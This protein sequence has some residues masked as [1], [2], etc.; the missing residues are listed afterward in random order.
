MMP[1]GGSSLSVMVDRQSTAHGRELGAELRAIREAAGLSGSEFARRLGWSPSKISRI[2]HGRDPATE[3]DVAIFLG[4][5]DAPSD[6]MDRMLE[7]AR[8]ADEGSLLRLHG[9]K[10]PD[11]LRTLIV[12]ETMA[13]YIRSYESSFIPGLAQTEDYA[14]AVFQE[15]GL[16]PEPGIEL[17]V[18]ARMERQNLL[19]SYNPPEFTAFIHE[20]VLRNV[21]GGLQIMHEQMLH[22]VFL[23]GRPQYV[24]RVVPVSAGG[25]GHVAAP[26]LYLGYT[27]H[28]PVVCVESEAVS[29]LLE[30]PMEIKTYRSILDR[31][32]RVALDGG[33]SREFLARLASEYDRAEEGGSAHA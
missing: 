29:V 14:R 17:R 26:F 18:R 5:L 32:D 3:V 19:K 23:S 20:N 4:K 1:F 12:N 31:L 8:E 9:Q 30:Q 13:D 10:L 15:V 22:L 25:A 6:I 7:L 21:V 2:E 28:R 24:I 11:E 16:I 27:E 33:Q